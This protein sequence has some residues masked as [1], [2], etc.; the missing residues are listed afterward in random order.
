MWPISHIKTAGEDERYLRE[1]ARLVDA[2][3]MMPA[4]GVIENVQHIG[5]SSVA[6]LPGSP[7]VDIGLAVWPFPLPPQKADVLAALGYARLPAV[8][9]EREQ[10]FRRED[11]QFQL[12]VTNRFCCGRHAGQEPG[13]FNS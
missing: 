10:R 6:G 11:G 5:A 2:L 9:S 8:A 4:G 12:F 13:I 3:G 7:C 1:R